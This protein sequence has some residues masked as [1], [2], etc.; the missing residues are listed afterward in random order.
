MSIP[1][2]RLYPDICHKQKGLLFSLVLNQG[3]KIRK[4]EGDR[5]TRQRL[6]MWHSGITSGTHRPLMLNG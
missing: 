5:K 3:G 6:Q 2:Q 1:Q 4:V